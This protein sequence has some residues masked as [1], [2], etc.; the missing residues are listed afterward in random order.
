LLPNAFCRP[1]A[2]KNGRRLEGFALDPIG[3]AHF[4]P[5]DLLHVRKTVRKCKEN[6]AENDR[7]K[8]EIQRKVKKL[9]PKAI[10]NEGMRMRY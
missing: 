3:G 5:Q 2:P 10:S 8:E 6:K 7:E 4:D 1:R 9:S